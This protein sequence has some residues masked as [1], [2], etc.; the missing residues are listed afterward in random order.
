MWS[1]HFDILICILIIIMVCSK[2]MVITSM[3]L[4]KKVSAV[5]STKQ[6]VLLKRYRQSAKRSQLLPTCLSYGVS[7]YEQTW[8]YFPPNNYH[9][10]HLFPSTCVGY[11]IFISRKRKSRKER[12]KWWKSWL[13]RWQTSGAENIRSFLPHSHCKV[14]YCKDSHSWSVNYLFQL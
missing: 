4:V 8:N 3:E 1:N 12:W 9:H 2:T 7:L 14:S 10:P 5:C 11:Y 13:K 6:Y